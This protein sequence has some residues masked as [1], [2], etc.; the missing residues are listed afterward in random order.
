MAAAGSARGLWAAD[1]VS[2]V[3]RTNATKFRVAFADDPA[4]QSAIQ[5]LNSAG[6]ILKVDPSYSGAAAQA[7]NALKRG[8]LSRALTHAGGAA[9]AGLGQP[10]RR[11][12]RCG[13]RDCRGRR[14]GRFPRRIRCRALGAAGVAEARAAAHASNA[15]TVSADEQLMARSYR[16]V[17]LVELPYV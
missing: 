10:G 8:L 11:S 1:R 9:G 16:D 5:D 6:Q 13:R 12:A 15:H 14:G 4:A 7:A 2:N 17:Q 3:L